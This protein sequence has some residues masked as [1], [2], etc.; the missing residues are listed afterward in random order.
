MSG[1]TQRFGRYEIL[2]VLGEGAMGV[3]YRARDSTLGR[4]VALKMLAAEAGQT[5]EQ[6]QR[7]Q[8]EAE[9]IG[10]LNHPNIVKVYDLGS[11]DGRLYMAMELLEGDD[12]RSG[13]SKSMNAAPIQGTL[14]YK[15]RVLTSK[16]KLLMVMVMVTLSP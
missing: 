11:I 12:L 7:F 9:A 6:H 15:C 3:V 16:I 8:R 14:T 2:G 13:C 4:V 1:A 10:R 5:S